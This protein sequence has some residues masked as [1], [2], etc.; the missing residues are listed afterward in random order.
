MWIS[1]S[2]EPV[3]LVQNFCVLHLAWCA[4]S[5]AKLREEELFCGKG[6]MPTKHEVQAV[7][8]P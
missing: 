8:C 5:H 2:M 7:L 6:L 1:I 4:H 3:L